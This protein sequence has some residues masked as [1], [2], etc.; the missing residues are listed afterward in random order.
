MACQGSFTAFIL[1]KM[2]SMLECAVAKNN[3][4]LFVYREPFLLNQLLLLSFSR[5]Q[6]ERGIKSFRFTGAPQYNRTHPII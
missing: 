1:Q 5:S 3:G 4:R 2:R 6:G